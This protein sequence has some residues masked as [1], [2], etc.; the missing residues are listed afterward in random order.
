M[1]TKDGSLLWNLVLIATK[2]NGRLKST[3]GA[4][5]NSPE[6]AIVRLLLDGNGREGNNKRAYFMPSLLK[7]A[8][9]RMDDATADETEA[10]V[11][12]QDCLVRG[13]REEAVA[14]ASSLV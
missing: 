1:S 8:E 4:C 2:W 3:Y 6:N 13:E 12:I 10:L 7:T 14:R 5:P 11:E 9:G